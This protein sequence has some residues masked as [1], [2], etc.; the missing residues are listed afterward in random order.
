[1]GGVGTDDEQDGIMSM[2]SLQPGIHEAWRGLV[3]VHGPLAAAGM[4]GLSVALPLAS[5]LVPLFLVLALVGLVLRFRSVMGLPARMDW[6]TPW[7]WMVLLFVWHLVGMAW[8][9][10]TAF[11]S[12]DLQIK[13]PMLAVGVVA[14]LMPVAA[15]VGRRSMLLMGTLANALAVVVCLISA[16][17]RI[18]I[19][20]DLAPAQEVFSARFSYFVHPSYFA[21]YLAI[22]LA[23]WVLTDLHAKVPLVWD[24]AVSLLLVVGIVLCGSKMG[25]I[26]LALLLPVALVVRWR[27]GVVRRHVLG[28][29]LFSVLGLSALIGGSAFARERVKEAWRVALSDEVD[30]N[31]STSSAVRRLTWSAAQE[32]VAEAPLKGTGTGDI[33]NE[34][35]RLYRE[36]GQEWAWEHRLNAHSQYL[37]TAA[38]LGI[39]ALVILVLMLLAPLL[40]RAHRHDPLI[41]ALL[42][43][44]AINW[45]VESM[46]EVQAGVVYF[47]VMSLWVFWADEDPARTSSHTSKALSAS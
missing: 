44:S 36:R 8:T 37:Q 25:W 19:G 18:G 34:L 30:A 33:K 42:V 41:W 21:M 20:T 45:S 23:A 22:S 31:A 3:D 16:V 2:R 39:G 5:N 13:A 46:L 38:C 40:S 15:R 32:L 9:D 43:G 1:M 14:M 24:R 6:S 17:V 11:G 35:M 26:M 7:P 27:D 10:D 47:A 29:M 28:M 12:F 4:A